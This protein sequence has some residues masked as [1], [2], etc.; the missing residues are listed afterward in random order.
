MTAI[1]AGIAHLVLETTVIPAQP[2]QWIAVLGL[3]LGPV[4]LAFYTWD[5]GVKRGSIQLLGVISY[6]TPLLST[7]VLIF[8]G[9][10][11]A[12][13]AIFGAAILISVGALLAA[14]DRFRR[15]Y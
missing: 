3:G 15:S 1:L 5:I 8:A 4:G 12:S 11:E 6:A 14:S 7:L 10:G 13:L 2:V 9:Q